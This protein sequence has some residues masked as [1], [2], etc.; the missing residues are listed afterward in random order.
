M[1][2][3][4]INNP[5]EKKSRLEKMCGGGGGAPDDYED[6][7]NQVTAN[8][9]TIAEMKNTIQ[10]MS[11]SDDCFFIPLYT[12]EALI[13]KGAKYIDS[14]F[15]M[16][17]NTHMTVEG[18]LPDITKQAVL[19]G[20]YKSNSERTVLKILGKSHKV[21]SQ[22]ASNAETTDEQ[23]AGMDFSKRFIYYQ[24]KE[25]TLF[26]CSGNRF[27]IDNSGYSGSD[28]ET[29]LL[30]FNQTKSGEFNN[31]ALHSVAIR[32]MHNDITESSDIKIIGA[33]KYKKSDASF[34]SY[35][36]IVVWQTEMFLRELPLPDGAYLE[37]YEMLD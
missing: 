17:G 27:T 20:A 16:N 5:F 3:P 30:L 14:G 23:V 22:W 9:A 6:L 24:N 12:R 31:G 34:I 15:K 29:P 26:I 10:N 33:R 18:S 13:L 19:A 36:F 35:S 1:S 28:D 11:D 37:L 7:K 32:Q 21:Q 2:D 8:T 4:Y 25:S